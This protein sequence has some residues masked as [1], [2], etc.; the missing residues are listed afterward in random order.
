MV[1]P[2]AVSE[3]SQPAGAASRFKNRA[4]DCYNCGDQHA[5]GEPRGESQ[6]G[7]AALQ[8]E[9]RNPQ[10]ELTRRTVVV[11]F[12]RL[13]TG[14]LGCCGNDW[15]ETPNLDRLAVQAVLFDQHFCDNL[16]PAAANHAWWTGQ[17]QFP[18]TED[19]QRES[20]SFVDTLH[21]RGVRTT[22][23]VESDGRDETSIAPPFGEVVTVCGSDGFDVVENETPFARVV[24]RCRDWFRETAG[25][26]GPAL[27]WIKSRG[28]PT[29]WVP[30][31]AFA[32]LYLDEFGLADESLPQNDA[33]DEAEPE[34]PPPAAANEEP[35]AG[36][37]DG[38]LDW[39][40]AAA[41][42][43]AYVTLVDRWLGQLLQALQ[44]TPGWNDALLIVTAAAGQSLGEHGP[45]EDDALPLR[46]EMVQTPLWIRVPGSDQGGT[47]R[48]D[49]VQSVD[50][51]PTVV[52]WMSGPGFDLNQG[53]PSGAALRR[54]QLAPRRAQ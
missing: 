31:Q 35:S 44:E 29:P 49:L 53:A 51:A 39:R 10:S 17:H 4:A 52:E 11:S 6:A 19:Q 41:M 2:S 38:S 36:E 32:E 7:E 13:H 37:R 16:D 1:L 22:L 8:S 9:I 12:D 14:F 40:Y 5:R 21:A 47:R 18:L 20:P 24:R 50:V 46:S 33:A 34:G 27:L 3:F 43:A 30:P 26:T 45:L 28:I 25:E 54:P 42:Y 15:I 48:Q 23:I